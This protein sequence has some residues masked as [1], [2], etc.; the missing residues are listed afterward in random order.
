LIQTKKWEAIYTQQQHFWNW[1]RNKLYFYIV[2][3]GKDIDKE[4]ESCYDPLW[5]QINLQHS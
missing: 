3:I 2:R 4:R 1:L 5:K